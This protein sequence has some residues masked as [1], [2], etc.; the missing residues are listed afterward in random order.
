MIFALEW[1]VNP[2]TGSPLSTLEKG[3][4]IVAWYC[5]GVLDTEP[6]LVHRLTAYNRR[7]L[8]LPQLRFASITVTTL[9]WHLS[10]EACAGL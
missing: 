1:G 4:P 5:F 9:L 7:S 6:I 10:S 2:V 3:Q 8:T